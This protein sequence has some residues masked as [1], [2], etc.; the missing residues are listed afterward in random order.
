MR[1]EAYAKYAAV[2]KDPHNADVG[3]FAI[4]S[5]KMDRNYYAK[6]LSA[7]R[8]DRVYEIAAPRVRQY[9]RAEIDHVRTV[10]QPGDRVLELGC[11]SGR[12][13]AA[14]TLPAGGAWGVDNTLESVRLA[15]ERHP[16]YHWAVM[17]AAG[18]GLRGGSFDV[19]IGVQNFIS[20]C[21][22]PPGILLQECLRVARPGGRILLSSYAEDFWP[23][24]LAWFRA[25]AEEGLLGS[26][27]EDATG[28]GV[29]V[30]KDGF[31]A[32]TFSPE[33]F[34]GLAARLGVA[35]EIFEIDGSSV[36]CQIAVK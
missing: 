23:H 32:T 4:P 2:T 19:V 36:F 18:L 30:G 25:Q 1:N 8:L 14:L 9:L 22:V 17:D 20:A 27:D 21:K 3:L 16:E 15:R 34:S 35:A 29:I 33:D 10:I 7:R 13:L 12:V 31:R 6:K 24:R 28:D 5:V 11:G 26:I